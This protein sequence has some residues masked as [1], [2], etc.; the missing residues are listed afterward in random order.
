MAHTR[1]PCPTEELA[2]GPFDPKNIRAII[3]PSPRCQRS[4]STDRCR[5]P[6]RTSPHAGPQREFF[7]PMNIE[8]AM[9]RLVACVPELNYV[10]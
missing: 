4:G 5:R 6:Q 10:F 1:N 8:G 2:S 9:R 7:E 3:R